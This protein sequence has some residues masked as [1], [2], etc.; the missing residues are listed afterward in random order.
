MTGSTSNARLFHV[1]ESFASGTAAAIGD[2]VRNYP[3]IEH[4]LLYST[5]AEATVDTASLTQFA[6]ATELPAGTPNR[7]RFLNRTLR[8]GRPAAVHA[9]SSKAGVYV[10]LA[11]RNSPRSPIVYTPHCY[12]FERRDVPTIVRSGFRFAEWLL[13]FNTS[14]IGACSPRERELSQWPISRPR[15]VMVPNVT[16][17]HIPRH[18][19]TSAERLRIIGNGRLGPQ[20]DARFFAEAV[21]TARQTGA[22]VEATWIGGGDEEHVNLLRAAEVDV[23]GWL[24]R[25]QALKTLASGDVYLHTARWEG[26]PISILEAAAA[27]LPVI[28]RAQPYIHGFDM[29]MTI[30]RPSQLGPL[31]KALGDPETYTEQTE[32]TRRAIADN[33]DDAQRTALRRL[34]DPLFENMT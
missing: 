30:E 11:L 14:A 26:F 16:P 18:Q 5:R 27:G 25:E 4:H 6:S 33:T 29:P 3:D 23:T 13:S 24:N 22:D 20:K 8:E 32:L 1:T 12:A 9:H 31:L 2:Y 15:A 19:R 10:R 28:A 7:I 17:A 21:T 34:Y